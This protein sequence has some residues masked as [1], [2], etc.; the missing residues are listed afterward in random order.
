[1]AKFSDHSA[2]KLAQ[3]H[4][5][6]QELFNA[7]IVE[8]DCTIVT[9]YRNQTDQDKAF[10]DGL[11]HVKYPNG[12]HNSKPSFAVDA[13]PSPYNWDTNT[14]P[15]EDFAK[16]VKKKAD[17]LGICISWGGDWAGWKDTDHFELKGEYN[18]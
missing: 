4:E 14:P 8:T 13:C 2:E 6:L 11:S 10:A 16:A 18:G 5:D 3:C 15:I 1:M 12:K 9:G 7:L 17:E